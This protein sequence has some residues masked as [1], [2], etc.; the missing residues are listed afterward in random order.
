MRVGKVINRRK[1]AKHFITEIEEERF[2][3]RRDEKKI[4]RE[5]ALDGVYVIRTSVSEQTFS[6]ESAVRRLQ[7]SRYG[8]AGVS[9]CE[10]G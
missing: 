5:A 1:V 10:D 6:A 9:L 7:G 4:A 3:Y 8:R 2:T